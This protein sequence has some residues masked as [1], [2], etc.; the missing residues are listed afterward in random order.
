MS[1]IIDLHVPLRF[2][3]QCATHLYPYPVV[4]PCEAE[5]LLGQRLV[6]FTRVTVLLSRRPSKDSRKEERYD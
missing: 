5:L 1:P 4:D 6:N 2:D 3:L